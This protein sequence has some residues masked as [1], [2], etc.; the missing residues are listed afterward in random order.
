MDARETAKVLREARLD[1]GL[2]QA[3]LAVLAATSQ[4]AIAAYETG[5][6]EP[7]WSVLERLVQ[8]SGHLL[9]LEVRP[10]PTVPL[11]RPR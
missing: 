3:E 1:A 8:A 7:P 9:A 11:G 4:S 10:D 5:A 2:T 6:R